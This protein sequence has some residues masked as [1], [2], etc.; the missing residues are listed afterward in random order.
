MNG[1]INYLLVINYLITRTDVEIIKSNA[2]NSGNHHGHNDGSQ[3]HSSTTISIPSMKQE[4]ESL[5]SPFTKRVL[6]VDDDRDITFTF[7]T[8]LEA[9][10]ND[11]SKD[12]YQFPLL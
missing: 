4:E 10:N 9:E 3:F 12:W 11:D 5:L 1:A 7:K 8:G 6:I 2:N